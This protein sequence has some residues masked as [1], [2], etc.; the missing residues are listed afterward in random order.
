MRANSVII[1]IPKSTHSMLKELS[2][3]KQIAMTV[4]IRMLVEK[5]LEKCKKE[6][7]NNES[8]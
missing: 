3:I 1:R 7:M 2:E 8:K 6:G 4:E 5:E